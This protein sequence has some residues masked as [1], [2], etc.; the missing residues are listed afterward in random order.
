MSFVDPNFNEF[1][2]DES[3]KIMFPTRLT[4][5]QILC[6]V[7]EHVAVLCINLRMSLIK[8][9]SLFRKVSPLQKQSRNPSFY[10]CDL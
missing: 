2:T 6:Y 5:K 8:L 4:V 1:Y 10:F 9:I 7:N 3:S